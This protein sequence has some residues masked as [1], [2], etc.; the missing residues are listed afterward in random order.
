MFARV[1]AE[2]AINLGTDGLNFMSWRRGLRIHDELQEHADQSQGRLLPPSYSA[3]SRRATKLAHCN[4][5]EARQQARHAKTLGGRDCYGRPSK[6]SI[7]LKLSIVETNDMKARACI[8]QKDLQIY[9]V[10][11]K[12]TRRKWWTPKKIL[13]VN[14]ARW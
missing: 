1:P 4:G 3:K 2:R 14:A 5:N 10:K 7:R 6:A 12:K 8:M 11:P 13:H 9:G